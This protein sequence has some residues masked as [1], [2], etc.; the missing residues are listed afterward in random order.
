MRIRERLLDLLGWG[1]VLLLFF[2]FVMFSGIGYE[3]TVFYAE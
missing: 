3:P 1:G 2:L